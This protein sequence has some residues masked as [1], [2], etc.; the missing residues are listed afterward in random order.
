M[1]LDRA[2]DEVIDK[3]VAHAREQLR[4]DDKGVEAFLRQ[5]FAWV[6]P[7]DLLER[8][9]IDL[10]GAALAHYE[11]ARHR[12]P[13]EA[14]VRVYTPSFEQD[15]WQSPHTAVAVVTDDMPFLV[16]SVT[17]ELNRRGMRVHLSLHPV[18]TVRRTDEGRLVDV[19]PPDSLGP[20]GLREAYIHIEVD[21]QAE[22]THDGLRNDL[23]R[24][25]DDVRRAV[26]DWAAMRGRA[27][28][29]AAELLASPPP[30]AKDELDEAHAFIEWIAD[31]H[32]TFLGY[33]EYELRSEGGEDI[34]CSVPESG[35]GILREQRRQRATLARLRPGW[36]A[37][38][39]QLLTLTKA[40]SRATVHR[41]AYLDYIGV[42]R[43]DAAGEVVGERRFLGLYTSVAYNSSVFDVPIL[44]RKAE[45]V[46]ARADFPRSGHAGKALTEILETYP[47]DELFPIDEDDLFETAMGILRLQ[48]RQRVRLFVRRDPFG[49]FLSCLVF[50]PRD[51]Y[52]TTVRQRIRDILL[53]SFAGTGAEFTARITESV[54]A[55]LHFVVRTVPGES[56]EADVRDVEARIVE[57]VRSWTDDLEAALVEDCGEEQ[58]VRLFLR[59]GDAFPAAYREDF[60]ART[61]ASDIRRI[62]A[63]GRDGDL[64]MNLYHPLGL[65]EGHLRLKL[66]GWGQRV[67]LSDVLPLLENMGVTVT[68]ERPYEVKPPDGPSLWIYDF[69]LVHHAAGA[70]HT[71]SVREAFQDALARAWR[72]TAENDGFNRL[73]LGARLTWRQV[74]VL[75]AYCKYLRQTAA[76]F[77]QAYMEECLAAHPELSQ[78]L[79]ELFE[80]RFDP[81]R[82]DDRAGVVERLG[83][84]IAQ[85]I[86]AVESLDEDRILRSF[87]EL[88][89]ATLR[90][91]HYQ[92]GD[93]GE[94]K[95]YLSFKLDPSRVP[96]LPL[97]RP[98]FEIFVCSPRMEGVHL[99]GG[100]VARGGLRWSDRREDFR[101]EV[102]GLMKAQ[103]VKNA[104]IVPVGAKGGF[105]VKQPPTGGDRDALL[106]EVVACYRTFVSGL[107]DLTDNLVG[108]EIVAPRDVVRHD[109][110]DRYLVVAADKGTATFSDI[111]NE[112]STACGFWLGDAF[113]SGGSTGYDHKKMGITARGAWESVKRHFRELGIDTQ[114]TPFT[115]IGIGDM[116]GDVFGN[117]MLLSRHIKLVGAFDH[118]HVLLDPDPDPERSFIERERLFSLPRSSWDD[119]DRSVLSAGGGV[120]SRR[121]KSIALSS[122]VR[123]M[124]DVQAESLTPNEVI[125]AMLQAPVDLLWNGG[126]GTYVKAST[127]THADAADKA[128]DALRVDASALRCRVVGEG[129]NLGFTQR[130]RVQYALG[131]G[132]IY[133][134]AIDNSAGVDCS[135]HEVNIKILL[136]RVVADGDM[137]QKQRNALLAEMTDEVGRQVVR[138]NYDHTQA[139]A[140]AG[141]QASSLAE[142]HGRYIASLEQAGILDR[143]LEFLPDDEELAERRSR[144]Q[145]LTSPEFA[146]LLSY[147]KIALYDALL[148]SDL[149]DDPFLTRIAVLYFPTPLRERFAMQI[150]EHPLRREIIATR[151]TN[152]LVNRGG[153]TFLYRLSQETRAPF[154]AITRAHIVVREIFDLP[155]FWAAIEALDNRVA[156]STQVRMLLETRTLAERATRWLLQNYRSPIDLSATVARLGSG[157]RAL[158]ATIPDLVVGSDRTALERAAAGL[159]AAG[160]PA[161]LARDVAALN[162]M[163]SALDIVEIA[164]SSEHDVERVGSFYFLLSD[165]LRLDWLRDEIVGLPRDDRWHTLARATLR[166]DLYDQHR[167]LTADVVRQTAAE[168]EPSTSI[169][170]WLAEHRPVVDRYLQTVAEIDAGDTVDLAVLSVALRELR[171]LASSCAIQGART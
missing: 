75:R 66:Y 167:A 98:M 101:S 150:A 51:R 99:R 19:L 146:V 156:A 147:T 54:L 64:T 68:D 78:M 93:D 108:G 165:R 117:G 74:N 132:R 42:K 151:V 26:T 60:P 142:V 119:Y 87:Y 6:A 105:V 137:T 71:G 125:R 67:S 161:E 100:Q 116:S 10:C 59:F 86:D 3:V 141:A 9:V 61:A 90:T 143:A 136:D 162:P 58:G 140:N 32:F 37:R 127:E 168:V 134:D 56:P 126:I 138:D 157:V 121:A 163:F 13:G 133:T 48:E 14:I 39:R 139:L 38:E 88:I 135:D 94:P 7:D 23:L 122:E 118:R 97:P 145:G 11:L 35:L 115:A 57:A 95:P 55:R 70:L 159:V 45:A 158:A 46:L 166:S 29:I 130:A 53:Q 72:G 17:M 104:V 149:P 120:F 160:V 69:G 123:Q 49:R 84:E 34:L 16:D 82:S 128:N 111:A 81:T 52:N 129:G 40:D 24:V 31:H 15:G 43:F 106:Q 79:V 1:P 47:R 12:V 91:N 18:I 154:D 103:M 85:R 44:R 73:V 96:D 89:R 112:I 50:V 33:R 22:T 41:P 27:E 2:R 8:S 76:T 153:T 109:G 124:L 92:R 131:G 152:S 171:D 21:R 170:E 114:T 25:L 4:A 155:R 102:L 77:S 110:D 83:V 62:E 107:L 65:P 113:A 144:G 169:D 148:A 36:G 63:L 164:Q 30:V 20:E 28:A 5:Y 80:A